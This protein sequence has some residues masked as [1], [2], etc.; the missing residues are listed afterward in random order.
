[1]TKSITI[2]KE[3]LK[4]YPG[5]KLREHCERMLKEQEIPFGC[6]VLAWN[7]GEQ[8]CDGLF[9][10]AAGESGYLVTTLPGQS[11]WFNSVKINY[12]HP[13]YLFDWDGSAKCPV[14]D[15]CAVLCVW[16]KDKLGVELNPHHIAVQFVDWTKVK[17]FMV[18]P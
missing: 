13:G 10:K 7:E 12:S 15:V 3:M 2:T 9:M 4:K 6:P 5:E 14:D 18:I 16:L 17:R 11:C 1:M 8:G